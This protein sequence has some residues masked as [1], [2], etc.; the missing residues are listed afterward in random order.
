MTVGE[1][2]IQAS[3]NVLQIGRAFYSARTPMRFLRR[4]G[5]TAVVLRFRKMPRRLSIFWEGALS[6]KYPSK[7]NGP[8]GAISYLERVTNLGRPQ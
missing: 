7:T 3:V 6:S 2:P 1:S 5:K 4:Q 8:R